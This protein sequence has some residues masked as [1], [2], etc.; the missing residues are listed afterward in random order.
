[1]ARGRERYQQR[2]A[3]VARLGRGLSRRAGNRCELCRT[4]GSLSVVEI[5][6]IDPEA[7]DP[8]RAAMLC[9]RCAGLVGGEKIRNPDELRFLEEAIWSEV[10]PAQLTAVRLLR[11]LIGQGVDWAVTAND[12]LYLDPDVQEL[13]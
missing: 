7:P 6:P 1:M 8:A 13:V 12:A 10:L 3:A 4:S 5:A 11:T 9:A 2:Q